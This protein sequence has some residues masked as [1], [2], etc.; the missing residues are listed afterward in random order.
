MSLVFNIGKPEYLFPAVISFNPFRYIV[1][2]TACIFN[3][4]LEINTK[5]GFGA[6]AENM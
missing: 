1:V 4:Y 3:G 5:L 6:G 2:A